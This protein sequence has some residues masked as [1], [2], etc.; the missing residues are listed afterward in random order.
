MEPRP[1]TE[2]SMDR[3][4]TRSI[5]SVLSRALLAL[6]VSAA[7]YGQTNTENFAQLKFNFNSPGARAAGIGGA[8]ISIADDATAAES[9]PAGLT[10]LIRPEISFELKAITYRREVDNFATTNVQSPT[11]FTPVSNT[12]QNSVL[13][14]SFASAVYSYRKFT[15]SL[16]RHELVH[17][18]SSFYTKMSLV[19]PLNATNYLYLY[20]VNSSADLSVVNWGGSVSYKINEKFSVGAS[21]GLSHMSVTSSL[22]RYT[23]EVFD[24]S[25]LNSLATIDDAGNDFFVNAGVI[26]RPTEKLSF[27]AIVKRRPSFTFQHTLLGKSEP[28]D[29]VSTK[30]IHFHVPSSVGAGV[31]YRPTDLLTLAFDADW[32]MYSALTKD[33]VLTISENDA[34]SA[35]FKV[36]NGFEFH[37]GAEYVLLYRHIGFVFRGGGYVEPDNKIRWVGNVQDSN[38]QLRL[39]GRQLL[40]SLFK[41]GKTNVHYTFGLGI[42]FSNS[43]QLDLAGNLSKEV[44]EGVGSFVVR[45]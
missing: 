14:P 8:F 36:D 45:L 33:F 37:L 5:P 27:G 38:D 19:P 4:R 15:F 6:L 44:R 29:I 13:S 31:S 26:Y 24:P 20:P 41:P 39:V 17:F 35:D 42:V 34:T 18:S 1:D 2:T 16:F 21:F 30:D 22:A 23:V 25:T 32:I 10:A 40:A 28:N 3:H 11:S 9:N 7:A 12:F 43:L